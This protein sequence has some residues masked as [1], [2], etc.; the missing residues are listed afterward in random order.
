MLKQLSP[1]AK[2]LG[3]SAAL[4]IWF[5]WA[6]AEAQ[7]DPSAPALDIV[8]EETARQVARA[9]LAEEGALEVFWT[10]PLLDL[11]G[12]P[13]AYQIVFR[14]PTSPAKTV[15]DVLA[16]Q[17]VIGLE[18]D[19]RRAAM[20]AGSTGAKELRQLRLDEVMAEHFVTVVISAS[21]RRT[22]V[23]LLRRGL[24]YS[25][26]YREKVR[27]SLLSQLGIAELRQGPCYY[28]GVFKVLM[29]FEAP[30]GKPFLG[31]PLT[32]ETWDL[33]A[34]IAEASD[35]EVPPTNRSTDPARKRRIQRRWNE[36]LG[37]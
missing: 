28:A 13:Y 36:L 35:R 24:P 32:G 7:T 2:L 26:L 17:K 23:P 34:W 4:V 33:A 19:K 12:S 18:L 9:H 1:T 20:S 5:G 30:K 37:Q 22:P 14:R 31:D 10:N 6:T 15:D 8:S 25:L 21:R 11:D 16:H 3:A 27:A 29:S